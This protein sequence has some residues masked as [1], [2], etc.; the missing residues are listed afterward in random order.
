MGSGGEPGMNL[1][2]LQ[3]PQRP[4]AAT[5]ALRG[6]TS[7]P[8]R[9]LRGPVKERERAHWGPHFPTTCRDFLPLIPG[10][11][12]YGF[13]YFLPDSWMPLLSQDLWL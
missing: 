8:G 4:R 2:D 3:G 7:R 9:R 5:A 1:S 6:Q 11:P 13:N 12:F 10:F